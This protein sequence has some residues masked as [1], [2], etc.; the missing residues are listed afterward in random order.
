MVY[1][2]VS[3]LNID[4]VEKK[5]FYH[6]LPGSQTLSF[7]T[8]GCNLSCTFCQNWT[9]SQTPPEEARHNNMTPE[10]IVEMAKR[11]NLKALHNLQRTTV[12]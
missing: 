2:K 4:P 6:F 11:P 9:L 1:G 8:T 5:P 7:A 10:E 12:L 3:A